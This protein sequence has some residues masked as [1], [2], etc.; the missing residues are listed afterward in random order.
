MQLIDQQ[1]NPA[2]IGQ[3]YTTFRGESCQLL[4][5]DTPRHQRS[6]GRVT[7]KHADDR[8]REYYPGVIGLQWQD[9]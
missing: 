1:G 9:R 3:L 8:K 7:V 2:V 5:I 4:G 6:T